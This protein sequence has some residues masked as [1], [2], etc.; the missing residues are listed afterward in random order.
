MAS[1]LKVQ[2]QPFRVLRALLE[3]PGEAITREELH[4]RRLIHPPV[5]FD[6]SL[7]RAIN[8]IREALGY[9]AE[10]PRF[11]ETLARRGYRFIAPVQ[12]APGP[13]AVSRGAASSPV[14][15]RNREFPA[16]GPLRMGR[17]DQSAVVERRSCVSGCGIGR[18][19]LPAARPPACR[20]SS[21]IRGKSPTT[22]GRKA[23][24]C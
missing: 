10:N 20:F 2:D 18:Y 16:E 22:A 6:Q 8:K 11:I 9:E 19:S 12:K 5:D 13:P 4:K 23:G 15:R 21:N 7:N 24:P 14:A 3:R 17:A 1:R